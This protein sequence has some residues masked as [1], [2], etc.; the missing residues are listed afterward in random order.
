MAISFALAKLVNRKLIKITGPDVYPYLQGLLSN[1]L[2]Y[3]YEPDRIVQR[4]HAHVSPTVLSTFMLNHQ[5]RATCDM[6]LY[7]TPYTRYQCEFSPP[8]KATEP[9]ELLI[10]CESSQASGLANTLYAYRVRRRV[11]LEIQENLNVW[12]LYP[13]LDVKSNFI[14]EA[15]SQIESL[16][17]VTTR[18]VLDNQLTLVC[19]PRLQAMGSRIITTATDFEQLKSTLR[20]HVNIDIQESNFKDYIVHRYKLGVSEGPEDHPEGRVFA[21]ECNADLLGS[22]SFNKGCYLGQELTARIH[23]TGV[24]RKRLMP[25]I[26][27]KSSANPGQTVVPMVEGSEIVLEEDGKKAGVLRSTRRGHGLALLRQELVG[28][29]AKLL[30]LGTNT[31]ITAWKPFWFNK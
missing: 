6:L 17:A 14:T 13:M 12:C 8:G 3:L 20:S 7:R 27:D 2:R 5:G 28:D 29:S 16:N 9:D 26:L 23:F 30:H 31:K 18:E 4:K 24:V 22:V 15:S 25:I 10:E 1:D 11:A 21:L 19:D